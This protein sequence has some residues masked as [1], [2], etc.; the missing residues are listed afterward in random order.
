MLSILSEIRVY[1]D[2]MNKTLIIS[3][4]LVLLAISGGAV[5][6]KTKTASQMQ[7]QQQMRKEPLGDA[8]GMGNGP[9][10]MQGQ[11]K[12][13]CLADGCLAV[14][15]LEFPVAELSGNAK[16][17]LLSALDD[18]YKAFATYQAIMQKLGNVRPFI[19]I[20]RAE[21]QHISSL[22]SL[23]DK[24]GLDVPENSYI[25]AINAPET[26]AAACTA[27]VTAEEENAALY[28]DEL[29]PEVSDYEDITAVFK[30]LMNASEQ[31]HLPAFERCAE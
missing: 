26:L 31:K 4:I 21:E 11:N 13:N 16:D 27:G 18:E 19:M 30:N 25:G 14:D 10:G 5:Y 24:Y 9:V 7:P 1:T 20:S 6:Y 29:L 23:F 12:G 2:F 17:A 15:D 28:N 22:K 8:R 3:A